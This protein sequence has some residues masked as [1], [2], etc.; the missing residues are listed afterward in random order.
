MT[1]F[2]VPYLSDQFIKENLSFADA[3]RLVEKAF[4]EF[5]NQDAIM[6]AKQYL[7]LAHFNG[8]F[9]AMPAYSKA[10]HIAGIKWINVHP[11]NN[12]LPSV[13]GLMLL[14]DPSTGQLLALVEATELTKIRTAAACVVAQ[15]YLGLSAIKTIAIIGLGEQAKAQILALK[16]HLKP[17]T[18][19]AWDV[20]ISKRNT[21]HLWLKQQSIQFQ[22]ISSLEECVQFADLIVTLTPSRK[23]WLKLSML[24]QPVLICAMGADGPGKQELAFEILK[25]ATLVVD[26]WSQASHSGE[27][28]QA[29]KAG[30]LSKQDIDAELGQLIAG[31]ELEKKEI[32][33]F[34]S[35]G[36]AIQDLVCA[37]ASYQKFKQII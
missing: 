12:Q 15:K 22:V 3:V 23:P 2:A 4:L 28:H 33:V 32:V 35:T 6:P 7:N 11:Q 9:R 14:N 26:D 18:V 27:I 19:R 13:M 37:A 24:N 1:Q 5:Y 16:V 20:D 25:T 17:F 8:D 21:F 31:N 30:Y 34:D 29:L 36:L 10:H